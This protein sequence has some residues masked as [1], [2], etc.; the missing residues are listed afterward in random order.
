MHKK[1][2]VIG[3]V[4]LT[5]LFVILNCKPH[6]KAIDNEPD[7]TETKKAYAVTGNEGKITGTIK[8]D[9]AP[10]APKTIDMGQD[11]QCAKAAGDKTLDDVVVTDGKLEN[12]FVYLKGPAIDGYSFQMPTTPVVL[13]QLGCRYH[14]RVLGIQ[15]GQLF[16]VT[17]S[18]QT[19]HNVHPTPAKNPEWNQ[20]QTPGQA[21]IEKKFNKAELLIPVKCNQHPWM[22]A[23]IG[24]VDNP[25]FAVSAKDG[26]FTINGVPPGDY[27]IVAWH[28]MGGDKGTEKTAKITVGA[29]ESKTQDFT[30]GAGVAYAPPTNL[31]V[32]PALVLP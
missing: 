13:D 27:T 21:A 4:L 11:A 9:G 7:E 10:P 29:K 25:F 8:F 3:V 6:R 2:G 12:V 26:T 32:G 16:R 28:E 20:S 15:T 17:N 31:K 18:D 24:V 22:K 19:T 23:H 30:F 1:L 5:A 14:P